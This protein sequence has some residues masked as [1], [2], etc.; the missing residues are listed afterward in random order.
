[1]WEQ[2]KRLGEAE[3]DELDPRAVT[4]LIVKKVEQD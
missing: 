1:V 4:V 2:W 3:N